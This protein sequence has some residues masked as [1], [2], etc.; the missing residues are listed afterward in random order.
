MSCEALLRCQIMQAKLRHLLHTQPKYNNINTSCF[1]N[2]GIFKRYYLQ[3]ELC[4]HFIAKP[5]GDGIYAI[6][7]DQIKK[8]GKRKEIVSVGSMCAMWTTK[9]ILPLCS[10]R[11]LES[12]NKQHIW[13]W[14][15][16][17]AANGSS[18]SSADFWNHPTVS[19]FFIG[20]LATLTMTKTMLSLIPPV[21]MYQEPPPLCWLL[22]QMLRTPGVNETD[23]TSALLHVILFKKTVNVTQANKYR[24][25]Q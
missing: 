18:T 16:R 12:L 19:V 11:L 25:H 21:N 8:E 2:A 14:E 1:Q 10:P 4:S 22:C 20:F 5:P 24:Y 17:E 23:R 15:K 6:G 3:L 9:Q 7:M 13:S